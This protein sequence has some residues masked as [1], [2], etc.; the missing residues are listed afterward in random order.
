MFR[1]YDKASGKVLWEMELPAGTTGEP[2]TYMV[3]GKQYIVVAVG[4]RDTPGELIALAL[5]KTYEASSMQRAGLVRINAVPRNA[6]DGRVRSSGHVAR[7]IRRP[8]KSVPQ[9]TVRHEFERRA[10]H[11][12]DNTR[13]PMRVTSGLQSRVGP[14][15]MAER[16]ASR[17]T[18]DPRHLSQHAV[19]V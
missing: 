6:V 7:R 17:R 11:H 8:S 14:R 2:V 16:F 1:A 15:A 18:L 4:W 12:S 19:T 3:N 5:P 10:Q 13:L 9:R